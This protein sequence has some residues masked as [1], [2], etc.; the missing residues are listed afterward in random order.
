MS[1]EN[2]NC[3]DLEK[4]ATVI[5][6]E[7]NRK[8]CQMELKNLTES[9]SGTWTCEFFEN[10]NNSME[11]Q[12]PIP[13]LSIVELSIYS[14][15]GGG[16]LI[17]IIIISILCC[18]CKKT[19]CFAHRSRKVEYASR[20]GF[21]YDQNPDAEKNGKG[22]VFPLVRESTLIPKSGMIEPRPL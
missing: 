11:L 12:V 3:A 19:C 20:K 9:D 5:E 14:A 10:F 16:A 15:G 17:L 18:K 8:F 13:K 22:S 1:I 2:K 21:R 7:H 4:R 6:D